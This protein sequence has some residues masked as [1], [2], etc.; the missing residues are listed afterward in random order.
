MLL[1][2]AVHDYRS[3]RKIKLPLERL[4]VITGPNGSGKSSLYRS[5]QLLA[6]VGQGRVIGALANEGGL[7]STLWAGPETI[8]QSVRRGEHDFEGTVRKDVIRSHQQA[9]GERVR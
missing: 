6:A 4:N 7:S 8:A 3:L 9:G 5:L 1:T 2:F